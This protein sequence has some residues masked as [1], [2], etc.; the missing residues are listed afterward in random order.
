MKKPRVSVCIATYNQAGYLRQCV[1]SVLQQTDDADIELEILIGNDGST[2]ASVEVLAELVKAFPGVVY[3][4]NRTPNV[5]A[6]RNYQLLVAQA[7]G[8]YIAHLDGDDYWLP[9]KLKRQLGY[10]DAHHDCV[11]VFTNAMVVDEDGMHRGVFTNAHPEE[12]DARYLLLRGNFLNH[13]A[14]LYR[15]DAQGAIQALPCPFIDYRIHIRLASLGKLGNIN[16]AYVVYRVATLTS[17][18]R[19]MPTHVRDMFFEALVSGLPM[20]DRRAKAVAIA[21]Y[22]ATG[23]IPLL[24][25]AKDGDFWSRMRALRKLAD[26]TWVEFGV[27]GLCSTMVRAFRLLHLK[28]SNTR[29]KQTAVLHPRL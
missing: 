16:D 7:T 20:L 10:L 4:H 12:I 22:F 28:V 13:S 1:E 26:V 8:D 24:G 11:A 9:G 21:N 18:Q 6:A 19:V 17:M 29:S 5:G 15:A 2:D 23:V 14:L 27:R 25:G 3:A